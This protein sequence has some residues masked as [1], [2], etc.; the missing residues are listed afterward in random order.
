MGSSRRENQLF[1]I[2]CGWFELESIVASRN[3]VGF[4]ILTAFVHMDGQLILK[5]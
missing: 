3:A 1:I 2:F 5:V 4:C